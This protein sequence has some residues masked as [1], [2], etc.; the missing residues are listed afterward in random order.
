M[1]RL[2][3]EWSTIIDAPIGSIA[4]GLMLRAS[5]WS[6]ALRSVEVESAIY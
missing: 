4:G 6:I 1:A 2:G 3:K 5:F